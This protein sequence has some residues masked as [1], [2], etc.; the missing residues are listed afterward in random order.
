MVSSSRRELSRYEWLNSFGQARIQLPLDDLLKKKRRRRSGVLD[1]RLKPSRVFKW[2][3]P[4]FTE[5]SVLPIGGK[6]VET[7]R[8]REIERILLW[9]GLTW[10][11]SH[12]SKGRPLV[13][14]VR[15][16]MYKCTLVYMVNENNVK[17]TW[18]TWSCSQ[19][20]LALNGSRERQ[21]SLTQFSSI[22]SVVSHLMG[23]IVSSCSN[24]WRARDEWRTLLLVEAIR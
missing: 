12:F 10:L 23:V 1:R 22:W 8:V 18:G 5:G 9:T 15:T 21:K 14:G 6:Y 19:P 16:Y 4:R 13:N 17:Y 3:P 11:P 2:Y 7:N 20:L 24:C